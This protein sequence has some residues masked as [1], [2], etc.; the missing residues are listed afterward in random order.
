VINLSLTQLEYIVAV[1]KHKNF[2]AA[3]KSCHVTQPTLSMQIQKLEEQLGV[4]IFDRSSQPVQLTPLGQKIVDQSRLVL[5]H[6]SLIGELISEARTEV[7]GDLRI[8][9][10]P[11]LAPYL[12]PLFV[13]QFVNTY[14]KINLKVEESKT[15]DIIRDLAQ[16]QIDVGL[17]VTPLHEKLLLEF[18]LFQE[19]FYIYA[20][21]E[22]DLAKLDVVHDYDLVGHELLLLSEGHCMRDQMVRVCRQR[23][24]HSENGKSRLRFESGSIET[25][26][27]LVEMGQGYTVVPHL[28]KKW[29]TSHSGK[30]IRFSDPQP[31]REVSLIVHRSF[32]KDAVL[33]ALRDCI[34]QSVPRDLLRPESELKRVKIDR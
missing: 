10:I 19:P 9:V 30:L 2:R 15:D 28:S 11:T 24:Q 29:L 4:T 13:E 5:S 16:N 21:A 8:A 7:A 32:V 34:I 26:C 17:L 14:P 33:N 6:A 18:P 25:L 23:R 22:S 12:L 1:E 3:A 27:H 20:N 31:S